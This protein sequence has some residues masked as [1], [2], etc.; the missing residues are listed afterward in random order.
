MQHHKRMHKIASMAATR[1]MSEQLAAASLPASGIVFT[2]CAA[3]L[4]VA[5]HAGVNK[6]HMGLLG[7]WRR[8]GWQRIPAAAVREHF[9]RPRLPV[10]LVIQLRVPPNLGLTAGAIQLE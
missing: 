8:L 1:L 6:Q 10:W 4:R 3:G 2:R 7:G 5:R 9:L